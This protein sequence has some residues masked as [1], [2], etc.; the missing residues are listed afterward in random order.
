MKAFH[1]LVVWVAALIMPLHAERLP[2]L[3]IDGQD[4]HHDWKKVTPTLK[5]ALEETGRFSV[6]VFSASNDAAWTA[7]APDFSRY[8]TVVL[9]YWG[10]DWPGPVWASF[11]K[12]MKNGG[13]LVVVH[14]ALATFPK[15]EEFNRMISVGWRNAGQGKRVGFDQNGRAISDPTGGNSSHNAIGNLIVDTR[16]ATHPIMAGFPNHWQHGPDEL[17][18]TLRG[19]A[20]NQQILATG[21]SSSTKVHEPVLWTVAYEKGRVF[22]TTLGHDTRSTTSPTF[23]SSFSRGAEWAAA[24]AVTLPVPPQL[25]AAGKE[26]SRATIESHID[27]KVAVTGP[28]A[29][30]KLPIKSGPLLHNPTAI[31]STPEGLLFVSNYTGEILTIKD[32]DKDGLED[33]T[34]LFIN[35]AEIG[36][37]RGQTVPKPGIVPPGPGLRYPTGMTYKDGWLYVGFTQEIRRFEV[38]KDG[39]CG[40]HETFASGWPYTMHAF[41]WT[42]GVKFGKDGHLYAILCTDYLNGKP[43]PDPKGLRGSMLRISPDG[44]TIERFACGLRFA[45]DLAINEAGDIFFTDNKSS[46]NP[47]EE[48]NHAVKDGNY[49]HHPKKPVS[50]PT[51]PILDVASDASPDGCEFNPTTNTRFGNTAGDL[52]IACWG[53]DGRWENGGIARVRLTKD[54]K[55][56][57]DAVEEVFSKGPGKV[58]DLT[59]APSGDM[60]VAR[61]GQEAPAEHAPLATPTGDVY[62]YIHAPWVNA[63]QTQ[64]ATNP[65]V[66]LPG[67]PEKG[68][69]IFTQRSCATCHTVDGSGNKLG[70]DLHNLGLTMDRAGLRESIENPAANIKTDYDTVQVTKKDGSE[71]VGRIDSSDEEKIVFVT[72]GSTENIPRNQVLKTAIIP[73]SLMPPGLTAGL[74]EAAQNDLLAYIESLGRETAVRLH[75][76]GELVKVADKTYSSDTAY[77][78]GS[79]GFIG[80]QTITGSEIPEISTCRYGDFSYRFDASDAEYEVTLTFGEWWMRSPGQRVFSVSANKREVISD[81]DVVK[82][83][84]FGKPLTRTFRVKASGGAIVLDFQAKANNPMVSLIEVKA[85]KPSP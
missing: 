23:K 78:S 10:T 28:Y 49:G 52:F 40:K 12:Y 48:L 44:K 77:H 72:A 80:G 54:A 67:V 85:V 81:L 46:G 29:A 8:R 19:P 70:P 20:R 18:H 31:T 24:G 39:T 82:E 38:K 41:D 16:I 4:S 14:A 13:G 35:A 62:R 59:F 79:Y 61:F 51:L 15:N 69:E 71:L 64:P 22:C 50:P 66:S 55:G 33:T 5:S 76:G 11:E 25:A 47:T 57:Y 65:L 7:G 26:P 37:P 63:Q 30:V 2:V 9:T 74:D 68:K 27:P 21:L 75:A 60:Y 42:F 84:G 58:S 45:Y 6:E 73:G 83:A 1:L 53:N 32:T 43:A 3:I 17:Y 56:T 36:L 34:T